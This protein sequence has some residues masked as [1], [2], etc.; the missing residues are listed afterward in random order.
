MV[1]P[2]GD[3]YIHV[4][5]DVQSLYPYQMIKFLRNKSM[6]FY[7]LLLHKAQNLKNYNYI[8]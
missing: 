4:C 3:I 6:L 1:L 5:K 8:Y 7:R 2:N